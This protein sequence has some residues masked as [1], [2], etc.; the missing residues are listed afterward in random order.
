MFS[1]LLLSYI[2][3]Y[4]ISQDSSSDEEYNDDEQEAGSSIS[5]KSGETP[6]KHFVNYIEDRLNYIKNDK[7]RKKLEDE[8]ID[9]IRKCTLED[10]K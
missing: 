8:I 2:Y 4:N 3:I 6:T 9:L 1:L 7:K 10:K 5:Q